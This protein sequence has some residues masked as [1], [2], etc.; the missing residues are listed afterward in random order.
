LGNVRFGTLP[1]HGIVTV[2]CHV[3]RAM[4]RDAG[5]S[6]F[7]KYEDFGIWLSG[8]VFTG[9]DGLREV[10]IQDEGNTECPVDF[11]END[12]LGY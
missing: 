9:S 8:Q 2:L 4:R 1:F 11:P 5:V 10:K 7:R 6:E 3:R 12:A